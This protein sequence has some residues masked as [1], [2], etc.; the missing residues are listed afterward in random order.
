[1]LNAHKINTQATGICCLGNN[2]VTGVMITTVSEHQTEYTGFCTGDIT[3]LQG[4]QLIKEK[5][6]GKILIT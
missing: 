3:L 4:I 2:R 1:M 6:A 5:Q